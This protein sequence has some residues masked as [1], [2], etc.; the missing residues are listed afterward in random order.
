M[1][2]EE[3]THDEWARPAPLAADEPMHPHRRGRPRAE[4]RVVAN[5]VLDSDD[6]RAMVEAPR[7][8]SLRPTCRRRFDDWLAD[9]TLAEI[10]KVLSEFGRRLAYVPQPET[11]PQP[12]PKAAPVPVPNRRVCAVS[13]GPT[14]VVA[15]DERTQARRMPNDIRTA[16]ITHVCT[17]CPL[18]RPGARRRPAS[19]CASTAIA[20]A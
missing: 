16:S 8:L 12:A 7:A 11:M 10:V 4:P 5:A 17:R 6:G 20:R 19:N 9:G 14:P 2:F 15:I 1:F 13:F 18:L 3:L